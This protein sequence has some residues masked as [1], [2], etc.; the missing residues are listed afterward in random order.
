M[1]NKAKKVIDEH[2]ERSTM[3]PFES[4]KCDILFSLD[5][6]DFNNKVQLF[7]KELKFQ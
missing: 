1:F 2:L 4:I 5:I 7:I 3:N 6:N